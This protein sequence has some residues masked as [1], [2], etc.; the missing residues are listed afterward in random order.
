MKVAVGLRRVAAGKRTSGRR[1]AQ[2]AAGENPP[3]SR[4]KTAIKPH[5]VGFTAVFCKII[6]TVTKYFQFPVGSAEKQLSP[7]RCSR[8]ALGISHSNRGKVN[9]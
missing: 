4:E 2:I 8:A 6:L 1:A 5:T 9:V 7:V 3:N